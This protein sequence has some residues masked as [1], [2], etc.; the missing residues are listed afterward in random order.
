MRLF[1]SVKMY[2]FVF[3]LLAFIAV[4]KLSQLIVSPAHVSTANFDID[5][6]LT[7]LVTIF[8]S[9][10]LAVLLRKLSNRIEQAAIVLI[11]I[12]CIL[13]FANLLAKFG[14]VWANIPHYLIFD[15]TV[16]CLITVLAG[17]RTFQVVMHRRIAW[18]R[19]RSQ[20]T[21]RVKEEL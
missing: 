4:V 19:R 8:I 14:F 11:E 16:D 17:V 10:Y 6:L 18:H 5:N 9:V 1:N 12:Q 20:R 15:T 21:L 3:C 13:W 2:V 7:A